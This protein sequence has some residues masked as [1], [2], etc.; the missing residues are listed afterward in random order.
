MKAVQVACAIIESAGKVFV[1]QRSAKM[2]LPLKWEFPGGKLEDGEMPADCLR[3]EIAEE[4][5]V[6]VRVGIGLKPSTHRY[7]TAIIT[8]HPFICEIESGAITL[9]EH[10]D[11][12][13]LERGLLHQLDWAEADL[14]VLAEYLA[15]CEGIS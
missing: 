2:V 11:S 15:V 10:S 3:R 6:S 12:I 8:L 9:H 7:E 5:G 1:A 13:W 4:L 14:P